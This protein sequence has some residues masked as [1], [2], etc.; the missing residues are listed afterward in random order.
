MEKEENKPV[1]ITVHGTFAEEG[2]KGQPCWWQTD[3]QLMSDIEEELGKDALTFEPF[4][5]EDE[6]RL[7]PNSER[8]RRRAGARLL[9]EKLLKHEKAGQPYH[10]IGHS[11]G[12]SVIWHALVG[13]SKRKQRLANLKS[14]TTV[15]T[16]FFE[17]KSDRSS[18]CRAAAA[19]A[20]IVI[21]Y[22]TGIWAT[23]F[24]LVSHVGVGEAFVKLVSS[25]WPFGDQQGF[26]QSAYSAIFSSSFPFLNELSEIRAA[27]GEWMFA[28]TASVAALVF[29]FFAVILILP[30]FDLSRFLV[31]RPLERNQQDRAAAWYGPQ[32][33]GL[34][35]PSDEALSGLKATLIRAPSMVMR[36]RSGLAKFFFGLT[37]PSAQAA[38]EFVWSVVTRNA[39]GCDLRGKL[40]H[41]IG[42]APQALAGSE[43]PLPSGVAERIEGRANDAAAGVLTRFRGQL[44]TLSDEAEWTALL[45]ILSGTYDD[46]SLIHSSM[47]DER[48]VRS[49]IVRHVAGAA[50]GQDP[51]PAKVAARRIATTIV[52]LP[53]AKAVLA[54]AFVVTVSALTWLGYRQ[55]VYEETNFAAAERII[56]QFDDPAFQAIENSSLPGQAA[57]RARRLGMP[58]DR[59]LA[60]AEQ[61][62]EPQSK[63]QA[64]QLIMREMAWSDL[65]ALLGLI[66]SRQPPGAETMS[67]RDGYHLALG[68]TSALQVLKLKPNPRAGLASLLRAAITLID[69]RLKNEKQRAR[70]LQLLI[71]VAAQAGWNNLAI[72]WAGQVF[73]TSRECRTLVSPIKAIAAR[74]RTKTAGS[75]DPDGRETVA[76]LEKIIGKCAPKIRTKATGQR[77]ILRRLAVG[78]LGSCEPA[79][80]LLNQASASRVNRWA[81]VPPHFLKCLA[82]AGRH[83]DVFGLAQSALRFARLSDPLDIEYVW[84]TSQVLY[85]VA[86]SENVDQLKLEADE[87]RRTALEHAELPKGAVEEWAMA[88]KFANDGL[89]LRIL[90]ATN[91]NGHASFF[92]ELSAAAKAFETDRS[93]SASWSKLRHIHA[94]YA[95]EAHKSRDCAFSGTDRRTVV[96]VFE[97]MSRYP[98]RHPSSAVRAVLDLGSRC[99]LDFEPDDFARLMNIVSSNANSEARAEAVSRLAPFQSS[100]RLS[101]DA[102]EKAALPKS[103]LQGYVNA[104]DRHRDF[105]GV[106]QL[107]KFKPLH[108]EPS[109]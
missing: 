101:L 23:L 40:V 89:K 76:L 84:K 43:T 36:P 107:A 81:P 58:F 35:H 91:P 32:W 29:L 30:F 6:G 65:G 26:D 39:Q 44:E 2:P 25:V 9:E 17:L 50:A 78:S 14:W 19:L 104:V 54:V 90:R 105:G 66:N 24:A 68:L 62:K 47:F 21:L 61:L 10:L 102:A 13:S 106:E 99:K 33:L 56:A 73:E 93:Y 60:A 31:S 67:Y 75:E 97:I 64:F 71:P 103:I 34:A 7:G 92:A 53:A 15:G 1:V 51:D 85:E 109:N 48:W 37:S 98:G 52:A 95:D 28:A 77:R 12:G 86:R 55:F 72:D 79:G 22:V 5:W 46:E 87:W 27:L 94:T 42:P 57:V 96:T 45:G 11:H 70:I 38:D 82:L 63:S 80:P 8:E 100:L 18:W 16:P 20:A 4:T 88:L 49:A 74:T 83:K 108:F 59:V 69:H 41:G 3:S